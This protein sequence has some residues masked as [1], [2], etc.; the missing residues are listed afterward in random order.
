MLAGFSTDWTSAYSR[1]KLLAFLIHVKRPRGGPPTVASNMLITLTV[2]EGLYGQ[3]NLLLV[4]QA[5]NNVNL[6]HLL[7]KPW[8]N[9]GHAFEC[10]C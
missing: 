5:L 10:M 8:R 6:L 1:D 3:F 4:S 2:M 7:R 9:S